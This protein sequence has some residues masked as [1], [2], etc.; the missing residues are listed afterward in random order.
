VFAWAVGLL[1]GRAISILLTNHFVGPL[2]IMVF[3]M[4][5]NDL[6]RFVVLAFFVL[7]PF[8]AS[9]CVLEASNPQ[10]ATF[11]DSAYSFLKIVF[12]QGPEFAELQAS[13]VTILA[14][15][16]VVLVV[17]LLNLLIALFSTTFTTILQDSTENYLL[18]KAQLLFTFLDRTLL[19]P[20]LNVIEVAYTAV[21]WLLGRG[22]VNAG[23]AHAPFGSDAF[24]C[25]LAT[26]KQPKVLHGAKSKNNSFRRERYEAQ[27][28]HFL[29]WQAITADRFL[30]PSPGGSNALHKGAV[31]RKWVQR[32]LANLEA[33]GEFDAEVKADKLMARV[34]GGICDSSEAV[35]ELKANDLYKGFREGN[36]PQPNLLHILHATTCIAIIATCRCT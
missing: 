2:L 21:V 27:K 8:T 4:L 18:H 3:D 22:R 11:Q 14:L 30:D 28:Q 35:A 1:W 29:E 32:V 34:I 7:M 6:S 36:R 20:P 15:G 25:L 23:A 12:G 31:Y 17:L 16:S 26:P 24:R 9:L 19:P 5:F 33:K 13:S 10:F